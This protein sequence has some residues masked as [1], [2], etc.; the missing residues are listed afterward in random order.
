MVFR[1]RQVQLVVAACL[2]AY[3]LATVVGYHVTAVIAGESDG[4]GFYQG[5]QYSLPPYGHSW[6]VQATA[7]VQNLGG[8]VG[9]WDGP[10]CTPTSF[11][12]V[13]ILDWGQIGKR[14]SV[15]TAYGGYG[16]YKFDDNLAYVPLPTIVQATELYMSQWFANT[17]N[18][19]CRLAVVMG[20]NNVNYCPTSGSDAS[21]PTCDPNTGGRRWADAIR[22]VSE[23]LRDHPGTDLRVD[24][25]SG[26]DIESP[27]ESEPL[28][29]CPTKTLAFN[30]GFR[31]RVGEIYTDGLPKPRFINYGTAWGT[32]CWAGHDADVYTLSWA[33]I[34]WPMPEIYTND[35]L[36]SW[37]N[38]KANQG[39]MFFLGP[40]STCKGQDPL[41]TTPNCATAEPGLNL[42]TPKS[43]WTELFNALGGQ[44]HL[45]NP[46]WRGLPYVTNIKRQQDR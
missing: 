24:I 11:E 25:W 40:L 23:W 36:L 20:V 2:L 12:R 28:W 39:Y 35:A 1:S 27:T 13:S 31:Q 8:Q 30:S 4:I 16:A 34:N 33:G 14:S 29:S 26:A 15:N 42:Y 18:T 38:V 7:Q 3:G 44:V 6:Y 9:T 45:T 21:D 10:R 46:N 43:A 22:D 5:P 32:E 41:P 17:I 37:L 19:T